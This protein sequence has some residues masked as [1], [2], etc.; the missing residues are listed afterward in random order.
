[1]LLCYIVCFSF[2]GSPISFGFIGSASHFLVG[3][4]VMQ[5]SC[6]SRLE[7]I[8]L[9]CIVCL[10]CMVF[11]H[12]IESRISFPAFISIHFFC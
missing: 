8:M 3:F 11:G 7:D 1:M 5:L 9:G 4:C 6:F 2:F 10:L 12:F